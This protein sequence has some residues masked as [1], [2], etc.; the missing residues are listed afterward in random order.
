MQCELPALTPGVWVP[1][2]LHIEA[3]GNGFIYV[4]GRCLGRYWQ[5]GPQRDFYIPETWLGFGG[6]KTNTIVLNLRPLGQ[7]VC[8]H[9][10]QMAPDTAYA[11]FR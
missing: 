9:A 11:E 6:G 4:N 1:W 5:A 2:H 8:V 3:N 10:A 7:G